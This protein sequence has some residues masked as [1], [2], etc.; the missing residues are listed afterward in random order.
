[1]SVV[2]EANDTIIAPPLSQEQ[3]A[4]ASEVDKWRDLITSLTIA[5]RYVKIKCLHLNAIF[6]IDQLLGVGHA[7][8]DKI[9]DNVAAYEKRQ[10]ERE[11][12]RTKLLGE[13]KLSLCS[14]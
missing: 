14:N 13:C 8:D 2:T 7:S 4:I 1:M 9:G 11:R 3:M 5:F 12:R 6:F 10:R